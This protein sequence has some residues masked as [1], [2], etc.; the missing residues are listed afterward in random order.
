MSEHTTPTRRNAIKLG[1]GA[2]AV[3]AIVS[4]TGLPAYA[5]NATTGLAVTIDDF[6]MNGSGSPLSLIGGDFGR[7]GFAADGAATAT[8]PT[9][10]D[11]AEVMG[12]VLTIDN[13]PGTFNARVEYS[14]PGPTPITDGTI[15]LTQCTQLVLE[16]VTQ[17]P[18]PA[19]ITISNTVPGNT[20]AL[21]RNRPVSTSGGWS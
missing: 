3:P 10:P 2:M 11:T 13:K 15:D 7:R 1:A 6:S 18:G 8:D 14:L 20:V 4:I 9:M 5:E 12:G 19:S 16:N 17:N 21:P